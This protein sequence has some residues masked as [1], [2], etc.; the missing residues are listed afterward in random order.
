MV[1]RRFIIA[2]IVQI[3]G[4]SAAAVGIGLIFV[5]AGVVFAGAALVLVGYAAGVDPSI[6]ADR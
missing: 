5:P 4:L 2:T 3:V 6:E 1:R